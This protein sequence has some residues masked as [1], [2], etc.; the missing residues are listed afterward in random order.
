M[1]EA[2]VRRVAVV[3][4]GIAGLAAAYELGLQARARSLALEVDLFEASNRLGG[5]ILTEREGDYVL[6]AG[7]DAILTLKPAALQLARE[8]DLE[9]EIIPTRDEDR[10]VALYSRGKLRPL[11]YGTGS[12]ALRKIQSF[13]SSG[14][15][16]W[17]G[18]LRMAADMVLPRG[19][20]RED[21]SMA[22]FFGRRLGREAVERIVDPL[23]AGI[24]SGDPD[25]LSVYSTFPRFPQMVA[26]RRSLLLTLLRAPQS[27]R[28]GTRWLPIFCS[29]RDGLGR[30]VERLTDR[31]AA[32]TLCTGTSVTSVQRSDN[33]GGYSL[34]TPQ[35]VRRGY[36]GVIVATPAW[37]AAR[38]LAEMAP[39]A[40]VKL[41][42]IRYVSSATV[43]FAFRRSDLPARPQGYGFLVPS[44]EGRRINGATWITNKFDHRSPEGG[45]LTRCFI[46]GDRTGGE[47]EADDDGLVR[48]C[49]AELREIAGIAAEPLFARVFRWR[50]SGPQYDVGH[51]RRVEEIDRDLAQRAGLL[52][53]GSGYRGIG[54]P[55]CVQDGRAVAERLVDQL[56]GH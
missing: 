46:G 25:R 56:W 15:V 9:D 20:E 27:A 55:D 37:M 31:L 19:P 45:F 39:A 51:A 29:L 38:L 14:V 13:V 34:L 10:G 8:I 24:Y 42:R 26:R 52:V 12:S 40:A 35:G 53:S 48:I 50:D 28:S 44:C 41:Q 49:R 30:L 54:I 23:V 11:P 32:T 47:L 22:D 17:P 36:A 5:A 18:K 3:G 21:E 6:D 1:P 7:P 16:S 33:N 4:G 43:F 2:R